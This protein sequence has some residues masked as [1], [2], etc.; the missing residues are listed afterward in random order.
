LQIVKMTAAEY[1]AV[2]TKVATTL[3][4]IVG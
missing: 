1:A 3:Y 2:T 4:V